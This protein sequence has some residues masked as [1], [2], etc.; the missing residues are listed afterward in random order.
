MIPLAVPAQLVAGVSSPPDSPSGGSL[1]PGATA[2]LDF[3]GS[4]YYAG[5]AERALTDVLGDG[6]PGANL[7][8]TYFTVDG[9]DTQSTNDNRPDAVGTLYTD[10]A[11]LWSGGISVVMEVDILTGGE[12]FGSADVI[13]FWNNVTPG[14]ATNVADIFS[15][16]NLSIEDFSSLFT[17]VDNDGMGLGVNKIGG[18]FFL[19]VGGGNFESAIC[20]NGNAPSTD[21]TAYG[22]SSLTLARVTIGH[23][24]PDS[25]YF[26][27][28][29]NNDFLIRSMTFYPAMASSALQALTAP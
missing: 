9:M 12:G 8:L 19:D 1:P 16:A 6:N 5:G 24:L 3:V 13:G 23:L 11:S 20:V 25:P 28:T 10:L 29:D 15:Q 21:T 22:P 7:N 26:F 14:S 17:T 18:T 27:G 2:H 4:F